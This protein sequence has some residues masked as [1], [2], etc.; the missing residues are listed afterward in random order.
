M[1]CETDNACTRKLRLLE[2]RLNPAHAADAAS[3][4]PSLAPSHSNS[5]ASG[6][7][8]AS[9]SSCASP[10]VLRARAGATGTPAAPGCDAHR[11]EEDVG[12]F[13][14]D[15]DDEDFVRGRETENILGHHT[16]DEPCALP[17]PKFSAIL[18]R[19]RSYPPAPGQVVAAELLG[20][21]EAP[22]KSLDSKEPAAACQKVLT[23]P[24]KKNN[25]RK[26]RGRA[27]A[28]NS[29]GNPSKL[30]RM[31]DYFK[32]SGSAKGKS[33]ASMR[34][35][36]NATGEAAD[37]RKTPV[38]RQDPHGNRASGTSGRVQPSPAVSST[39]SGS[40]VR[41]ELDFQSSLPPSPQTANLDIPYS[42]DVRPA[43][44]YAHMRLLIDKLRGQ[45]DSLTEELVS[46]KKDYNAV[47]V[48]NEDMRAQIEEI[49]GLHSKSTNLQE[50]LD[51]ALSQGR[52]MRTS[53][54]D[55]LVQG[56][57]YQREEKRQKSSALANRLG[58][59]VTERNGASFTEVWEDGDA[60]RENMERLQSIQAH[61]EGLEKRRKDTVKLKK[62]MP[63]P[64][65]VGSVYENSAEYACEQD[66]ILRLRALALKRDE[67]QVVKERERMTMERDCH[68]REV[69]RQRDEATSH[70]GKF[71][72]LKD[73]YLLLNLLGRGGFSE[74]FRAYD[75][76]SAQ[77]VACKV[78]Q[79]GSNW[80][81][82]RKHSFLKH[83]L[84]EHQIHQSLSHPRI[85]GAWDSFELDKLTVVSVL[86][87]CEGS[88]LDAVL[89]KNGSI[90]EREARSII[91]QI[92]S[93]L[94]Y[95]DQHVIVHYDLK[96]GN[97]LLDQGQVRITDF[98]LSK[99]VC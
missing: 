53:L 54:R 27:A 67:E 69:S 96:P 73:R 45:V 76:E 50:Q 83:M 46:I 66:E 9:R 80:S 77:F 32:P 63:P 52:R 30:S 6:S 36:P 90:S 86:D 92:F 38:E 57:T 85:L 1:A 22:Q 15:D 4:S 25:P 82:Q 16:D 31:D 5:S 99:Y 11:V 64:A 2:A 97:I 72:I 65:T 70:F 98:G 58:R 60:F 39:K 24:L 19:D 13:S 33:A 56:A 35:G 95:L 75:F 74:V 12:T 17:A 59:I 43:D 14:T 8:A 49:P 68:L 26:K 34:P 91:A 37:A 7:A 61:R 18:S 71:P 41:R 78:H 51:A 55:A 81:E 87:L 3:P 21:V 28:A 10:L 44:A 89:R 29:P 62:S 42:P 47:I 40:G 23:A 20:V 84:R 94:V 88:D 79:L 93:G 48:E